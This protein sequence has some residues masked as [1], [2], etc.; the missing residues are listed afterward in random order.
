MSGN[1]MSYGG[2]PIQQL[3]DSCGPEGST[4]PHALCGFVFGNGARQ[5][6]PDDALR[7]QVGG[8]S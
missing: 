1:M 8:R 5:P 6:P 3:Y 7:P 4:G 2:G